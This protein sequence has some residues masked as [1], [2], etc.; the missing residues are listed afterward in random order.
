MNRL[1]STLGGIRKAASRI[2]SLLVRKAVI[3]VYHRVAN[4]ANDPW[5]MA[6]SPQNFEEHL[7]VL[8]EMKRPF[9][10]DRFIEAHINGTLPDH[11][12]AITFD[13]GYA[14]S[15]STVKPLLEEYA[16]P[17][18]VF[19]PSGAIGQAREYWWDELEQLLLQ[20]GCLPEEITIEIGDEFCTWRFHD[21]HPAASDLQWKAQEAPKTPRQAAFLSLWR[22]LQQLSPSA[23]SEILDKL[24]ACVGRKPQVRPDYRTLSAQEVVDLTRDGLVA[25]GAHTVNHAS[26]SSLPLHLQGEEIQKSKTQLEQIVGKSVNTFAYPYG[27]ISDYSKDTVSLVKE[28]GFWGAC[29]NFSGSVSPSTDP[30][31]L[32]RVYVPNWNG[33][34]FASALY[35]WLAFSL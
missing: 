33:E 14:D 8:A 1:L 31:Q 20:P 29:A 12:I 7:E 35:H 24:W 26:L 19:L 34:Q 22:R 15:L 23:R 30:F 21:D 3:L 5:S 17:A 10:M 16:L 13:D 6:V 18:T 11:V 32:P 27:K 28:A 2:R 9:L 25:V 4:L